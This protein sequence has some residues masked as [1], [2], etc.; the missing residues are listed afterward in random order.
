V[1]HFGYEKSEF[2]VAEDGSR[3]L[4]CK[5]YLVEDFASG[6]ERLDEDGLLIGDGLGKRM[7]VVFGESEE[8]GERSWVTEDAEHCAA[9][10]MATETAPTEGAITAGEIDLASD[11]MTD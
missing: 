5:G 1:Q 6:C 11:A 7:K 8:F 3:E 10:A 2:A 9:G 4:R